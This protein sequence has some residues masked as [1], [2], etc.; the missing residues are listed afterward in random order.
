ME[1]TLDIEAIGQYAEQYAQQLCDQF[2]QDKD[3]ATGEDIATLSPVRQVNMFVVQEIFESWQAEQGAFISPYFD[4][5]APAVRKAMAQLF[6]VLSQHVQVEAGILQPLLAKATLETL[7]LALKPDWYFQDY[8]GSGAQ[9]GLAQKSLEEVRA[10]FKYVILHQDLKDIVLAELKQMDKAVAEDELTDMVLA[11]AKDQE[12]LE[13]P[14]QVISGLHQTLP[15]DLA[16]MQLSPANLDVAPSVAQQTQPQ[17]E[18]FDLSSAEAEAIASQSTAAPIAD[19]DAS[20]AIMDAEADRE[21]AVPPMSEADLQEEAEAG[22]SQPFELDLDAAED[23]DLP[24]AADEEAIAQPNIERVASQEAVA[25]DAPPTTPET[26]PSE[27]TTSEP[28]AEEPSPDRSSA[29]DITDKPLPEFIRQIPKDKQEEFVSELFDGDREAF[30]AAGHL[31]DQSADYHE[32]I[33]AV[34]ERYFDH[35]NW[36]L[37]SDATIEFL[38]Y[39]DEYFS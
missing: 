33:A 16:A 13:S 14:D 38:N 8:F 9:E 12:L 25:D 32:G 19:A 28:P 26:K 6:T 10:A 3:F 37:T 22:L 36:D 7:I 20:E 15:F 23:F 5:A 35:Y 31:V 24:L 30:L 1:T 27:A 2:Y 18:A 34:R 21:K 17:E 11:F 29:P 4:Y 39:F